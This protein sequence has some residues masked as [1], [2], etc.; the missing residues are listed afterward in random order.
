M[1]ERK[2]SGDFAAAAVVVVAIGWGVLLNS[3][4]EEMV[5]IGIGTGICIPPA[6]PCTGEGVMG[7]TG[8]KAAASDECAACGCGA[9]TS[10]GA[11]SGVLGAKAVLTW[12]SFARADRL[13]A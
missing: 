9:L 13:L 12:M 3:E 1:S 5:G 8:D 7:L 11:A 4:A 6:W 10:A 2:S